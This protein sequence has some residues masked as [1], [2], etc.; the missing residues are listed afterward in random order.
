MKTRQLILSL[1]FLLL[2]ALPA[3][4]QPTTS[5]FQQAV[6]EY[7]QSHSVSAAEKVIALAAQMD[8]QN[9]ELIAV[10]SLRRSAS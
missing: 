7:Q 4:A 9:Q 6:A 8:P 10:R 1:I 3:G 2:A 5:D